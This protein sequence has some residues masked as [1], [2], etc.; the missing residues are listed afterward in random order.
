[1]FQFGVENLAE[2]VMGRAASLLPFGTAVALALLYHAHARRVPQPA[3]DL[4]LFSL[5]AYRAGVG[6]AGSAG[7]G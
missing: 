1:M 4:S 2:P 5:R 6:G 7:W 3:L